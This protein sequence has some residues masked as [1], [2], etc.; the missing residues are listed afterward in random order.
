MVSVS[1]L[2][3]TTYTQEADFVLAFSTAPG[4]RQFTINA[5]TVI[6]DSSAPLSLSGTR[7]PIQVRNLFSAKN[8]GE[9]LLTGLL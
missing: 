1:T 8:A 4:Y 9:G 3:K 7:G 5:I 2:S 6:R